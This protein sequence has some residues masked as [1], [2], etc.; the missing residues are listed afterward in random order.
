MAAV[1]RCSER[2]RSCGAPSGIAAQTAR[3][4]YVGDETRDIEAARAAGAASGAV[5]WGYAAAEALLGLNPTIVFHD[6]EQLGRM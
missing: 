5:V 4:I 2:R 6:V 1:R 3:A